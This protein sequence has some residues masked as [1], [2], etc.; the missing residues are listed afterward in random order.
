MHKQCA[1]AGSTQSNC[2]AWRCNRRAHRS[3]SHQYSVALLTLL[4][5][6]MV[7]FKVRP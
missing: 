3:C 2:Q 4:L 6:L 7:L 1:L 5:Q